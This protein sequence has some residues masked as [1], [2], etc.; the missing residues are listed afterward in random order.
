[1]FFCTKIRIKTENDPGHSDLTLDL[2]A[3]NWEVGI[4]V[5]VESE[6]SIWI[7]NVTG[8]GPMYCGPNFQMDR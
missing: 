4:Q 5:M 3:A 1:M 8:T 2:I 6:S 7:G